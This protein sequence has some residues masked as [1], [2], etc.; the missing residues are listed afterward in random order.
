[1]GRVNKFTTGVFTDIVGNQ[2]EMPLFEQ[3]M[4]IQTTLDKRPSKKLNDLLKK[5]NAKVIANKPVFTELANLEDVIMRIRSRENLNISDIKLNVVREYIYARVP[6]HRKDTDAKDIRVIVGLV[7]DWGGD[8]K[9]LLNHDAFM[10][11]SKDKVI[12]AMDKMID[13]SLSLL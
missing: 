10:Q 7:A 6:F 3:F 8:I 2:K 12:A 13:E 5:Y 4:R 9:D 1:M 11:L